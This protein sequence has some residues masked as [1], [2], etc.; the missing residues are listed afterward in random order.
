M[1]SPPPP[2]RTGPHSKRSSVILALG[3][4]ALV[5]AVFTGVRF[6]GDLN[7]VIHRPPAIE[8]SFK[9]NAEA[10]VILAGMGSRR[11][12]PF[13][14]AGGT[15]RVVWSAW[16]PAANFPPC[17][18]SAE[19]V[20]VDPANGTT[21]SGHVVDVAKLVQVP[22]TGASDERYIANLKPGDYYLDITSECGWQVALSPSG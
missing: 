19:L 4:C 21:S 5:G 13:Y 20:A 17:T 15:Y 16:G 9:P 2:R 18:H 11:G 10:S 3:G 7:A 12:D 1:R 22:A 14:V 6:S 8:S